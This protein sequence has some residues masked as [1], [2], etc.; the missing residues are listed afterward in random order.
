MGDELKKLAWGGLSPNQRALSWKLLMGYLPAARDR[1]DGVLLRKRK[2][3]HILRQ[4]LFE[5][6]SPE[7]Q[8][9]E[10][11]HQISIDVPRTNPSLPL[12][13][14]TRVR[15]VRACR[16]PNLEVLRA[17]LILLVRPPPR[18]QLCPGDQ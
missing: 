10:L 9:P 1:R 18:L 13:Q 5:G 16:Y 6:S 15:Q 12:F 8:D 7:D 3:Y 11:W 4:T 14:Q 2:E 17:H